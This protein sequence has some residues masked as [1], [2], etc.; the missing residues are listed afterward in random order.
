MHAC[1]RPWYAIHEKW[2][3]A[4][5]ASVTTTNQVARMSACPRREPLSG[6]CGGGVGRRSDGD[7]EFA[8]RSAEPDASPVR[9]VCSVPYKL[10]G[11][12][13]VFLSSEEPDPKDIRAAGR[14]GEPAFSI[15]ALDLRTKVSDRAR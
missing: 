15:K 5:T 11:Q 13:G 4:V 10:A 2:I 14:I 7:D 9:V 8:G 1:V 3:S 6:W 12:S